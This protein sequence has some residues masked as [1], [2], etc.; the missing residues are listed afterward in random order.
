M[1]REF[2]GSPAYA[3]YRA[4]GRSIR[5]RFA[6]KEKER[7]ARE[8]KAKTA[9]ARR[10]GA[11]GWSRISGAY[12]GR[13]MSDAMYEAMQRSLEQSARVF[14]I[15]WAALREG[16]R[17]AETRAYAKWERRHKAGW[18]PTKERVW[19]A[20]SDGDDQEY[21]DGRFRVTVYFGGRGNSAGWRLYE[22][23]R[24]ATHV[25][26][27]HDP[28]LGMGRRQAWMNAAQARSRALQALELAKEVL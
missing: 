5:A 18:Q 24:D 17:A 20:A 14:E 12:G 27:A 1:A 21:V 16:R 4:E 10:F 3:A 28:T 15:Q 13:Q 22:K 23:R 11:R 8:E 26:L 25:V 19:R 6:Q 7:Q 2:Y 9:I